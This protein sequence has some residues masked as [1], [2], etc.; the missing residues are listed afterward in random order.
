MPEP[1]VVTEEDTI[2][3]ID[4]LNFELE[5][6]KATG[7]P[8]HGAMTANSLAEMAKFCA[9]NACKELRGYLPFAFGT[10]PSP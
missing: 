1:L 3:V 5:W 7:T 2:R 10:H 4:E 9:S 6:N 8:I